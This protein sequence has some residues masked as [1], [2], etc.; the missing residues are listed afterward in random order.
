MSLLRDGLFGVCLLA[1]I[2]NVGA[3]TVWTGPHITFTK[4]DYADRTLP[5]N[6]DRLTPNAW[7]TRDNSRGLYNAAKE[8][9]YDGL[10]ID[11][12]IGTEWADGTTANYATLDYQAWINWVGESPRSV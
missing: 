2:G 4:A 1:T 7:L 10:S 12:P 3:A 5:A 8:K 6:Q 9:G 11:S